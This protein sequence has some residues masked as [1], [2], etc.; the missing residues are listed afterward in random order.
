MPLSVN[1]EEGT[2]VRLISVQSHIMQMYYI[3]LFF[4]WKEYIKR[5]SLPKFYTR[6]SMRSFSMSNLPNPL[7]L[8]SHFLLLILPSVSNLPLNPGNKGQG[9]RCPFFG[10]SLYF[11]PISSNIPQVIIPSILP[12][13]VSSPPSVA[14]SPQPLSINK[15]LNLFSILR[16]K[17]NLLGSLSPLVGTYASSHHWCP[18]CCRPAG[19]CSLPHSLLFNS[20]LILCPQFPPHHPANSAQNMLQGPN[21]RFLLSSRNFTSHSLG[22]PSHPFLFK[23][24]FPFLPV[25]LNFWS[26]IISPLLTPLHVHLHKCCCSLGFCPWSSFSAQRFSSNSAHSISV[27]FKNP[28]SYTHLGKSVAPQNSSMDLFGSQL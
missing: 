20:P 13:V 24:F 21:L 26:L 6:N 12:S 4:F 17:K 28:S 2:T 1:T 5:Y 8:S 11:W 15:M 25:L 27:T 19:S 14:P 3:Y 16:K 10:P 22:L 23:T 9:R 18:Q 7:D